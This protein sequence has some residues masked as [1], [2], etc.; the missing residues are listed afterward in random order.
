MFVISDGTGTGK[1]AKVNVYNRLHTYSVSQDLLFD[2]ARDGNAYNISTGNITLTSDNES[3]I[4]YVK[5]NGLQDLIIAQIISS[6]GASTGGSGPITGVIYKNITGGT[7]VS[8]AVPT[9]GNSN[10]NFGSS[11]TLDADVYKGAEGDTIAGGSQVGGIVIPENT[12]FTLDANNFLPKDTSIVLS[13]KPAT[14]NTSFTINVSLI[15]Y[16]DPQV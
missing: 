9:D 7:I 5:N 13:V 4:L 8:N 10:F 11:N 6:S 3:P 14:G 2:A 15:L 1:Q 16:L 12:T